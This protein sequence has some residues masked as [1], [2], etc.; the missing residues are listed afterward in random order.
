VFVQ[1]FIINGQGYG[2]VAEMLAS[3][4]WDP[5]LRRPYFQTKPGHRNYGQ[6]CVSLNTGRMTFN[7]QLGR[8]VP[9]RCEYTI[10]Q[11]H[12][13]GIQLPPVV[14]AT[15]LRKEEWL[16]LDKVVLKAAR[17]RLRAYADLAAAN[18]F[19]GFNAMSKMILEHETMSDALEAVVDMDGMTPAR[20]DVPTYQLEGLPLPIT[21]ADFYLSSRRL[22]VSRNTGTPLDT[23]LGEQAGRRVAETIEKTTIGNVTGV[24]YGGASTH[25][26]G[27]GR[28]SRVYGYTNF[29][30]RLTKTNMTAPTAGGWVPST[31]VSEVL[32][33]ITQLADNKFFGPFMLYHSTDWDRYLDNDYYVSITSGAVAPTKTLR[34]RLREIEVIQDVRRL[35]M[36]FA[37]APTTDTTSSNYTGP[38]GESVTGNNAFTFIFVQMTPDVARAINGMDITT[39]QWETEGGM[40]LNFKVMAIQVPQLR[41]DRYGNCGILHATT[42]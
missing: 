41:A 24:T 42:S 10:Q 38:G 20:N 14:N 39:V 9:Q 32:A 35:D 19:G 2:P 40:K 1:D 29:P 17:Y 3:S 11:A 37:S 33:C 30:D 18:T 15:S 5:G 8:E 4:R 23:S 28:T 36:L 16:E 21:H 7:K 13:M 27:Y 12:N 34:Q 22:A 25:T 31:T 26:G 6:A